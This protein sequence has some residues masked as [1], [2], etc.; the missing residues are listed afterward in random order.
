MGNFVK[1]LV[2]LRE[3]ILKEM[4]SDKTQMFFVATL[5]IVWLFGVLVLSNGG[6]IKNVFM[7]NLSNSFVSIFF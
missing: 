3:N 6:N 7:N 4:G 1:A 5:R 2:T